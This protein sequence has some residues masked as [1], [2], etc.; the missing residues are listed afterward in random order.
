M[1]AIAFNRGANLLVKQFIREHGVVFPVAIPVEAATG[2]LGF[3][4]MDRYVV[5]QLAVIDRNGMI[6][7]QT[8]P[9]G[10]PNLQDEGFLR[11]LIGQLVAEPATSTKAAPRTT[12]KS[13]PKTSGN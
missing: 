4:V 3:S 12:P 8:P 13:A 10:D 9:A 6:R 5:P 2:F 11:K 1:L 7:A